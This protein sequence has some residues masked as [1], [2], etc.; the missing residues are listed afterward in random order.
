[1]RH[2]EVEGAENGW[3]IADAKLRQAR[4][5]HRGM[6]SQENTKALNESEDQWERAMTVWEDKVKDHGLPS[7]RLALAVASRLQTRKVG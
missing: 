5:R 1:M 4:A 2:S 3:K 6:P 7:D